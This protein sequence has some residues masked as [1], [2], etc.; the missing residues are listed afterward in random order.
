[1]YRHGSTGELFCRFRITV[2]KTKTVDGL[3]DELTFVIDSVA[4]DLLSINIEPS[5]DS[6]SVFIIE[7]YLL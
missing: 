3:V 1:M 4:V 5:T 6:C 7:K 2:L